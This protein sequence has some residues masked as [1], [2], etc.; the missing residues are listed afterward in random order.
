MIILKG[1]MAKKA[2]KAKGSNKRLCK[3]VTDHEQ[4]KFSNKHLVK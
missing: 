3:F 1:E 4:A 2:E